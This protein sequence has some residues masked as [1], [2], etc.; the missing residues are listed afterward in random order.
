MPI[1][2]ELE[3]NK[4]KMSYRPKYPIM[5]DTTVAERGH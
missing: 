5:Q 2:I 3:V 1:Q 4:L